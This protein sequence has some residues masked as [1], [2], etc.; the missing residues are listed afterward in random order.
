MLKGISP[1]ISPELLKVLCEMGHG[2]TICLAD[3]NYP[4]EAKAM[5]CGC[6]VVRLDGQNIVPLL[7][8]VLELFPLDM[9][10]EKTACLM[11]KQECDKDVPTPI[12]EE[13]AQ[14]LDDADPRGRN[15]MEFVDRFEFYERSKDCYC[16]VQTGEGAIY[17][18]IILKK[19]V[20]K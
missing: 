8:A 12:W 7:K 11:Q 20:V 6:K 14:C 19:G 2:D 10:S 5:Q 18:N 4:V 17:A 1:L 13:F 9:S 3:G 16:I 15:M